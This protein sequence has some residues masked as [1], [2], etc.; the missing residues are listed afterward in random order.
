LPS[1]PFI[2][3]ISPQTGLHVRAFQ[4]VDDIV[5]VGASQAVVAE[6]AVDVVIRRVIAWNVT[7]VRNK[8]IEG[9]VSISRYEVSGK[10]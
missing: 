2:D 6:S 4:T 9:I 1:P 5:A 7:G 8:D 3:I 10:R